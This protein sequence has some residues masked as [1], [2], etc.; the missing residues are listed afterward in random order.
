M[1]GR[2]CDD[3][4]LGTNNDA[5]TGEQHQWIG[6]FTRKGPEDVAVAVAVVDRNN[7]RDF[8]SSKRFDYLS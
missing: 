7:V 5:M 3:Q 1:E 8:D 2:R 4:M 6:G